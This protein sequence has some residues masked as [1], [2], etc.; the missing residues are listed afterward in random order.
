MER[1][2]EMETVGV[3]EASPGQSDGANQGRKARQRSVYLFPA[4][5]FAT[6]LDIAR[7]VEEGGAGNLTEDSLAVELGL[8]VKSSGFRLKSL[9][10]RQF[11]LL[12]KQ[13]DALIVTPTAKAILKPTSNADALNGYRQA[14]MAIPLFRA[15][16]ERYRGQYLPDSRS[17]RNVLQREFQVDGSRA[18]QAE[19][20]LM[21]SARDTQVLTLSGDKSYLTVSGP[22][23]SALAAPVAPT[24]PSPLSDGILDPPPDLADANGL[25]QAA[26][27]AAATNTL[28]FSLDE[29]AQ[30][31]DEDF[32]TVWSAFGLL[33]KARRNR[34]QTN[35]SQG[36][37]QS[38]GYDP[39]LGEDSD[40]QAGGYSSGGG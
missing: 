8:S 40:D 13:G 6:A 18:Q 24:A 1:A 14:F 19:K 10:A 36:G 34:D 20:L 9:T 2:R 26:E 11:Q 39:T 37:Y 17:L 33:V 16:A 3:G 4:Y 7:R 5:G 25:R 35:G 27:P 21:E 32:D 28:T 15:V 38:P 30:L 12:N 29:I 31:S 22:L 23:P